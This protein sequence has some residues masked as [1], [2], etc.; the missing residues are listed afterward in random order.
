[1]N[2]ENLREICGRSCAAAGRS[3]A[4]NQATKRQVE[5]L[6]GDVYLGDAARGYSCL[7]PGTR[8]LLTEIDVPDPDYALS[9]GI[10]CTV[11]LKIPHKTP[12][13]IVPSEAI[14]FNRAG[15]GV[16]VVENGSARIHSV[17]VVRDIGTSVEFLIGVPSC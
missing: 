5:S 3:K 14:T 13:P 16:A 8:T 11:E 2:E 9:P 17:T 1:V 15:L 7:Q 4:R 10:Y 12:S 6:R